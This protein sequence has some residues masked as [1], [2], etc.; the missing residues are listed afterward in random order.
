M[1]TSEFDYILPEEFIAQSP[2]E[3]RD[4][5]KL[6]VVNRKN[7]S[8]ENLKFFDII[9]YLQAGDM[10]VWN[11]SKV[12]KARLKGKIE[13]DENSDGLKKNIKT[14]GKILNSS[15]VEIFL[16][17]PMENKYVWKALAKPGRR[18]RLGMKVEFAPNFSGEVMLKEK[19]GTILIQFE[20]DDSV[21]R[22]KANQYGEVP[23]PPYIENLNS[24]L[25]GSDINERYQTVYAK[26][27]GSV[28]APTAGFHF[29]PELIE[30]LERKGVEFA[31]VTLHVGLG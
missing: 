20:D 28:A 2:A 10:L 25:K 31:E 3:P 6:M 9:D 30:K 19:D 22:A 16:V 11:S 23:T 26:Q 18:L 13:L 8:V 5:S 1:L 12:F 15:P 21:V 29:T 7:Q 14:T 24:E 17:R 4:S 27:E